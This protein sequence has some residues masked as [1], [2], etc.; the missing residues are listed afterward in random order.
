MAKM[1]MERKWKHC[2][3]RGWRYFNTCG[4]RMARF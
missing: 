4:S 1:T 3:T 2:L